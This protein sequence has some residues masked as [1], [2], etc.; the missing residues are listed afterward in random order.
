MILVYMTLFTEFLDGDSQVQ[1]LTS[2]KLLKSKSM[3]MVEFDN[4][5]F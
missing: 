1:F 2:F 5:V 3:R 4:S